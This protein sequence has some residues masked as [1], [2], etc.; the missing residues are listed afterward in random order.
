MIEPLAG[1]HFCVP[2]WRTADAPFAHEFGQSVMLDNGAFS[3]W[4]RGRPTN[5]PRYYKWVDRW[6]AFPTT[7]AVIPDVIN[8]GCEAQDQLLEEWP[9]QHRGA[10]VWHLDEPIA[11]LLRLC[12]EW[13]KVCMGS[14]KEYQIVM[15]ERW[16][17]RLDAAFNELA[18]RHRYIPWIHMLRGMRTVN[19]RWP[20][21]SLDSA[22][23]ARSYWQDTRNKDPKKMAERWDAIQCKGHWKP[24]TANVGFVDRLRQSQGAW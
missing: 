9:F 15:N 19:G 11:R 14:T 13:P 17:A 20:F 8:G 1:H 22:N 10:P 12:D 3:K 23:V 7:W 2:H 16:R 18:K 21:A 5:W 6:L 4:K 24:R